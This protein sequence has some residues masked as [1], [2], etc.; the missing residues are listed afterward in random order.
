L[1]KNGKV[2]TEISVDGRTSQGMSVP[3]FD[4]SVGTKFYVLFFILNQQSE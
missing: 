1:N 3:V 4:P 2:V